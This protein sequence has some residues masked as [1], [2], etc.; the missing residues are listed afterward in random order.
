MK[1]QSV[2][3]GIVTLPNGTYGVISEV[4]DWFKEN[5]PA[6]VDGNTVRGNVPEQLKN[7]FEA[8][9]SSPP[10]NLQMFRSHWGLQLRHEYA[11]VREPF[12]F[13]CK[14]DIGY[15]D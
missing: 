9:F 3:N 4:L 2:Q 15:E 6:F 13:K 8:V 11:F 5:Y 14:G 10:F 7:Y 1:N 12:Q